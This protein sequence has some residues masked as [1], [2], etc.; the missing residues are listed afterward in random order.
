MIINSDVVRVYN[1]A[2]QYDKAIEHGRRWLEMEPN[3]ATLHLRLANSYSGKKMY[4]E[5]IREA[6]AA[7]ADPSIPRWVYRASLGYYYAQSGNLQEAE[8]MY[9]EMLE[10]SKTEYVPPGSL[11]GYY[12]VLGDETRMFECLQRAYEERDKNLGLLRFDP[13]FAEYRQDP[14]YLDL[15]RKMKLEGSPSGEETTPRD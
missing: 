14:R 9:E 13:D 6:Q 10:H 2:G 8:K 3:S 4:A 7:A 15:I 11:A 12:L 5:A 1:T